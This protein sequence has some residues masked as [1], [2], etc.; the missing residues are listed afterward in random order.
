[1]Q[2]DPELAAAFVAG[3]PAKTSGWCLLC[4]LEPSKTNGYIQVSYG[5]AN[6]FCCLQEVVSWAAGGTLKG[7]G[8]QH[9]HRCHHPACA[10]PGHI[11]VESQKKNEI[12]KECL[13]WVDCPHCELKILVCPH[14]PLCIKFCEGFASEAEF[15]ANGVHK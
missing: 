4:T 6:H 1:M 14:W 12:R 8:D 13:V 9:S 10:V 11:C 15:L 2:N 3:L 7:S 5:G